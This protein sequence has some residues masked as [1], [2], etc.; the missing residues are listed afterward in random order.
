MLRY[1]QTTVYSIKHTM[2]HDYQIVNSIQ[3][4]VYS[5]QYTDRVYSVQYT[6][7][8]VRCTG[9]RT[10]FTVYSISLTH[11]QSTQCRL[12][13]SDSDRHLHTILHRVKIPQSG[14]FHFF[15]NPILVWSTYLLCYTVLK[16]TNNTV[17]YCIV[18]TALQCSYLI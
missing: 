15:V 18:S 2:Y 3:N 17:L 13:R 11:N 1:I 8:G 10:W 6:E 9:Y 14:P 4:R 16:F 12:Y 5:V 7:Q